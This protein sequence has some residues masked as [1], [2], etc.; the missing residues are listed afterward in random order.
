MYLN[1]IAKYRFKSMKWP[2]SI[3][4]TKKRAELYD[5]VASMTWIIISFQFSPV[6]QIKVVKKDVELLSK[7]YLDSVPST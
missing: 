1:I 3:S 4:W 6:R 7:L 2:T 5:F